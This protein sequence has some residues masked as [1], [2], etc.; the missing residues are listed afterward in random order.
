MATQGKKQYLDCSIIIILL[1]LHKVAET[2]VMVDSVN[3]VLW[4]AKENQV[5]RRGDFR[6]GQ[7]GPGLLV[8]M[9]PKPCL[10]E[11]T[12]KHTNHLETDLII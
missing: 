12:T 2:V 5:F 11:S 3:N 1:L 6:A 10:K 8:S 4:I 7:F 9:E